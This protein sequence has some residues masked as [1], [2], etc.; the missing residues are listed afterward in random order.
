MVDHIS[1]SKYCNL[2]WIHFIAIVV[3]IC[4]FHSHPNF[5][6]SLG[7]F[8]GNHIWCYVCECLHGY[9]FEDVYALHVILTYLLMYLMNEW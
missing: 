8:I 6:F 5:T 2:H 7:G 3:N 1:W 4:G 9:M